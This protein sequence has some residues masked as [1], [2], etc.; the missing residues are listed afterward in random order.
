MHKI[1][2]I[3]ITALT[4]LSLPALPHDGSLPKESP[5]IFSGP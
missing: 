5:W 2:L 1:A 4:A 3:G